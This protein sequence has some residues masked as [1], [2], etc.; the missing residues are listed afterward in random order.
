MITAE[1]GILEILKNLLLWPTKYNLSTTK[2]NLALIIYTL[3]ADKET[4]ESAYNSV[5]V[6]MLFIF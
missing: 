6:S 5:R 1:W 4:V 2:Y 3:T